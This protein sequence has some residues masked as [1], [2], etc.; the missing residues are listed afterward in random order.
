MLGELAGG[1]SVAVAVCDM[2]Q[3]T[4]DTRNLTPDNCHPIPD[5]CVCLSLVEGFNLFGDDGGKFL[6]NRT[7]PVR[8]VSADLKRFQHKLVWARMKTNKKHR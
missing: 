5:T 1:G 6:S 8:W 7:E 2:Q 4:G 3:A